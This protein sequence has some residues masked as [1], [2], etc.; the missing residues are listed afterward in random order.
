MYSDKSSLARAALQLNKNAAHTVDGT[1]KPPKYY[2]PQKLKRNPK[3]NFRR[4]PTPN[5]SKKKKGGGG[6]GGYIMAT[7]PLGNKKIRKTQNSQ[8]KKSN[9]KWTLLSSLLTRR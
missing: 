4:K 1:Q 2:F 9:Q 5:R 6:G 8:C 7:H 3:A